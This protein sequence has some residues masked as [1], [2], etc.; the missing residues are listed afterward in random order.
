MSHER[1]KFGWPGGSLTKTS[2]L[3]WL[4]SVLTRAPA[5][6]LNSWVSFFYIWGL[7]SPK[8][9]LVANAGDLGPLLGLGRSPGAGMATHSSILA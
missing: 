7:V 1:G 3:T 4:A 5:P 2:G 6:L 9:V 8:M